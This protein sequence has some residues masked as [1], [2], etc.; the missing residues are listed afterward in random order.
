MK[1]LKSTL[2]VAAVVLGLM[3]ADGMAA[4]GRR[5]PNAIKVESPFKGTVSTVTAVGLT[6]KGEVQLAN[7]DKNNASSKPPVQNVRF[8]IK[9]AKLTRD[10]KPCEMKDVQKGDSATVTFTTKEGSDKRTAS[11][12]DFSSGSGDAGEKKADGKK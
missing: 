7:P 1:H 12:I 6:V 5:D 9:G 3:A 10:G 4:G 2:V 11:Q 8:S